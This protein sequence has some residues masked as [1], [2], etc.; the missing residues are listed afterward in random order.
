VCACVV[1][2]EG[3]RWGLERRCTHRLNRA[4]ACCARGFFIALS[5]LSS[6]WVHPRGWWELFWGCARASEWERELRVS[7]TRQRAH[8][9]QTNARC[10]WWSGQRYGLVPV[11]RAWLH[12]SIL[13]RWE[14]R[15]PRLRAHPVR[16]VLGGRMCCEWMRQAIGEG[17]HSKVHV[18][19]HRLT[20]YTPTPTPTLTGADLPCLLTYPS[21]DRCS[22][23]TC[24]SIAHC[25]AGMLVEAHC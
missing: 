19:M 6:L 20:T 3:C 5:E 16:R 7:V 4:L 18:D 17:P 15:D 14:V 24:E 1:G 22:A 13:S 9:T 10:V 11:Q 23:L 8:T 21:E 12:A 25:S 2:T